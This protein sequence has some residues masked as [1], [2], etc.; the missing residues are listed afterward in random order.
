MSFNNISHQ[1]E[2]F[3][4]FD[5]YASQSWSGNIVFCCFCLP[6]G[7]YYFSPFVIQFV[8]VEFPS[9]R[10]CNFEFNN[11]SFLQGFQAKKTVLLLFIIDYFSIASTW[12]VLPTSTFLMNCCFILRIFLICFLWKCTTNIQKQ[13]TKLPKKNIYIW[14]WIY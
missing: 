13:I 6:R 8:Y 1:A 7:H 14:I 5:S 4:W 10:E 3:I 11:I 2:W 12:K 9:T